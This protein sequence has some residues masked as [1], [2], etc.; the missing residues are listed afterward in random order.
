MDP[1]V[2][3]PAGW[4]LDGAAL[5]LLV[6][7]GLEDVV[8]KS[9]LDESL[10][11]TFRRASEVGED[12]GTFHSVEAA[13]PRSH[14]CSPQRP[15]NLSRNFVS[16]PNSKK[17]DMSFVADFD[18]LSM[19]HVKPQERPRAHAPKDIE[20]SESSNFIRRTSDEESPEV[21]P[22]SSEDVVDRFTGSSVL[23]G[24][25]SA[26]PVSR[27]PATDATSCGAL[28]VAAQ[29]HQGDGA[30]FVGKLLLRLDGLSDAER[31]SLCHKVQQSPVIQG[32]LACLA[33]ATDI[34]PEGRWEGGEPCVCEGALAQLRD[35]VAQASRW[36]SAREIVSESLGCGIGEGAR[37][38]ASGVRDGVL[39][40]GYRSQDMMAAMASG[41]QLANASWQIC[42]H[43]YD[44][45]VFGFLSDGIFSCGIWLGGE[46]QLTNE[47]NVKNAQDRHFNVVPY[48][49]RR[50]YLP[51][52]MP[53]LLSFRPSTA[54]L[55]TLVGRPRVGEV[56]LDPFGGIGTIALEAACRFGGLTCITSDKDPTLYNVAST[57]CAVARKNGYLQPTSTLKSRHYDARKMKVKDCSID[58]VVSELPSLSKFCVKGG[59][60]TQSVTEGLGA[61]VQELCRI[62]RTERAGGGGAGLAILLVQN[63]RLVTDA[64]AACPNLMLE[65]VPPS[66]P[67]CETNPRLVMIGDITCFLFVLRRTDTV[68]SPPTDST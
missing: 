46:W 28:G 32:A 29:G 48:G 20:L 64:L 30:S 45:E 10:Q 34:Q 43:N 15:V 16:S 40:R 8:A 58:L 63:R 26:L 25:L 33:V 1:C 52:S 6:T 22:L 44:V 13:S 59:V 24:R 31:W 51:Q 50:P 21:V 36:E 3:T 60:A 61:V 37:F 9:L 55:M 4:P 38:R 53:Q 12:V 23:E 14:Q 56:L 7:R 49:D 54:L 47:G 68:V 27:C 62:L 17:D 11:R 41:A 42:S 5:L 19:L 18:M 2:W 39:H 66:E 57:H 35:V 65:L 67:Y